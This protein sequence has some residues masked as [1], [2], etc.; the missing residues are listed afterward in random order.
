MTDAR[1]LRHIIGVYRR[2]IAAGGHGQVAAF[3]RAVANDADLVGVD[4]AAFRKLCAGGVP[5]G[6][7]VKGGAL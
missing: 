6:L 2:R 4:L 3:H 1:L 7:A 5:T